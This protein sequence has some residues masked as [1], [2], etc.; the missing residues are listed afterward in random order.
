MTLGSFLFVINALMIMPAARLVDGFY[1]AGFGWALLFSLLLSFLNA[2]L[3]DLLVES[4][5]S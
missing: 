5:L 4:K 3:K 1:V 2:L